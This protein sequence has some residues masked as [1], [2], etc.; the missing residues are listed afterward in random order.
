M[1]KEF[2]CYPPREMLA[3]LARMSKEERGT[4][5]W[6]DLYLWEKGRR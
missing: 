4:H 1:K 5:L 3:E 6:F 2:S